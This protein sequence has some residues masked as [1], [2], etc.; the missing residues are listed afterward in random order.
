MSHDHHFLAI[1]HIGTRQVEVEDLV[2]VDQR[3]ANAWLPSI[4]IR[5]GMIARVSGTLMTIFEPWPL[6]EDVD[7]TVELGDLGLHHVH[8]HA[9]P[10]HVGNLGL[11]REPG[12][13]IRL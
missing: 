3:K 12:A 13:K 2:D 5:V 4:T 11:G 6:A 7:R 9:T 1:D 8:A 10:G